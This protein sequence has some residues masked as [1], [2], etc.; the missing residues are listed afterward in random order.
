MSER[1]PQNARVAE[2]F[3]AWAASGRGERMASS[4]RPN[5]RLGFEAL[6][7]QPGQ[8]YLDVGC[9]V[10][11]TVRWAAALDPSVQA[12]G[13]DLAATMIER[14]RAASAALPNARF[15]QARVPGPWLAEEGP[16][17]AIFSMEAL[18]YVDD[19]DETLAAL[20]KALRPG[21]R[22][23]CVIDYYEGNPG[24]LSWPEDLGVHM[25][26]RSPGEW[27]EAFARAG[28]TGVTQR[29]L[30]EPLV[31]GQAPGWKQTHGSLFTLGQR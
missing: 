21:G 25:H 3:D 4:H 9:G 19:P 17:D 7:L 13:V 14:A 2:I 5:A 8:R 20:A 29:R 12:L 30:T 10:G 28:F 1:S 16:F 15:L 18:Y 11:D 22:F 31:P 23:A 6:G 27:A 26:R 24:S